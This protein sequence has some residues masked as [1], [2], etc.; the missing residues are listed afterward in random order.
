MFCQVQ[1]ILQ[2]FGSLTTAF[3]IVAVCLDLILAMTFEVPSDFLRTLDLV[4]CVIATTSALVLSI[5]P[6]ILA[7]ASV[8]GDA[9]LWYILLISPPFLYINM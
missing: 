5:I 4:W 3:L 7:G 6:M 2:V 9:I 1:A 8:Y